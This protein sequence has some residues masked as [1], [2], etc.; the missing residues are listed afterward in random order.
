MNLRPVPLACLAGMLS[1]IYISAA[2]PRVIKREREPFIMK[3]PS[4]FLSS[5]TAVLYLGQDVSSLLS[6][7]HYLSVMGFSLGGWCILEEALLLSSLNM[8]YWAVRRTH[9]LVTLLFS[10]LAVRG[11]C[12]H[13]DTHSLMHNR[14]CVYVAPFRKLL[15]RINVSVV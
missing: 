2:G 8:S 15:N 6:H 10:C 14:K 4:H 5:P 12:D 13:F 1:V 3:L 11:R 7:I 9:Y